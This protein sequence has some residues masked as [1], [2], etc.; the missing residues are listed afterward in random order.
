M[1]LLVVVGDEDAYSLEGSKLVK[2]RV[3]HSTLEIVSPAGHPIMVEQSERLN[4]AIGTFLRAL[5]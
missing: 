1:P 2:S 3:P 4:S 5:S